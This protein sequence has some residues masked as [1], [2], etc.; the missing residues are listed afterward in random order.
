MRHGAA[1]VAV[2]TVCVV[3]SGCTT[4]VK[5]VYYGVRGPQ[6]YFL[7]EQAEPSS[8]FEPYQTLVVERFENALPKNITPSLVN[9]V[10]DKTVEELT[11]AELFGRVERAAGEPPA[12]A[13]VIRGKLLDVKSDTIPGQRV[14]SGANHVIAHVWAVDGDSGKV[15]AWGVVRGEVKS[16]ARGGEGSLGEGLAEG[17]EEFIEKVTGREKPE[18]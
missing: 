3:A 16:V 11:E 9:K 13:L 4:A 1:L 14:I 12:G 5:Q 15:L 18:D 6:G 17:I 8:T 2:V 10:L 7:L